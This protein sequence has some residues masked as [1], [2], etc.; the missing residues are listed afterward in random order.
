VDL[1]RWQVAFNGAEPVRAETLGRFAETFGPYGFRASAFYPCYGMA[2]A[3]LLISGGRRGGGGVVRHVDRAALQGERALGVAEKSDA[4]TVVGC[5]HAL[6]GEEIA[7]VDPDTR[8]RRGVDSLGE[9]WVRGA[10]VAASYWRNA[11]ASRE[12]FGAEIDGEAGVVWLRTGD[13]GFMGA[14][15]EVFVTGRIKDLI[16]VRGVNH[17]PQDIEATV[18]AID[19][20]MRP[21]FGAAFANLDQSGQE[22]V[23]IVHTDCPCMRL[24]WSDL[25][26]FRRPRVAKFSGD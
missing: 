18:Q 21:G 13:L 26:R 9:I 11:E 12:T 6:I 20:R 23:V 7:I 10:N 25:A 4:V 15:G 22:R 19:S 14:D 17:Y 8:T 16:I 5:G 3:T 24:F 1:S 2:E